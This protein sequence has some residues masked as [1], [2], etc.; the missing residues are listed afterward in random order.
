MEVVELV[1][2]GC[3]VRVLERNTVVRVRA[4]EQRLRWTRAVQSRS[5]IA[6]ER[7][8]ARLWSVPSCFVQ[9]EIKLNRSAFVQSWITERVTIVI[10]TRIRERRTRLGRQTIQC[11]AGGST[12]RTEARN[13][14]LRVEIHRRDFVRCARFGNCLRLGD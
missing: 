9:F 6:P 13:L 5:D 7:K 11:K 2:V 1:V 3:Q 12:V 4:E 10:A 14:L 8:N